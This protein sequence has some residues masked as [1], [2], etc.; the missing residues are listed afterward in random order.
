MIQ[1][2]DIARSSEGAHLENCR[3]ELGT[4]NLV[5]SPESRSGHQKSPLSIIRR[6][7]SR[8]LSIPSF[9]TNNLGTTLWRFRCPTQWRT[10][11]MLRQD[12]SLPAFIILIIHELSPGTWYGGC[13]PG[14]HNLASARRPHRQADNP[15]PH[16]GHTWDARCKP[17]RR[18]L[19]STWVLRMCVPSCPQ[20]CMDWIWRWYPHSTLKPV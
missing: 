13:P 11:Q 14:R 18:V 15:R 4:A 7:P 2:V 20:V 1:H 5:A 3:H 17:G 8:N 16:R 6:E 19:G 9:S 12:G 10:K